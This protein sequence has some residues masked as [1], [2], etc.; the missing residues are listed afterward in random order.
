MS[1]N[2][3][4]FGHR[5]TRQ[6]RQLLP[7]QFTA[8]LSEVLNQPYDWAQVITTNGATAVSTIAVNPTNFGFNDPALIVLIEIPDGQVA[9]YE[10]N[11]PS[12]FN[13]AVNAGNSSPRISGVNIFSWDTNTTISF[14]EAASFP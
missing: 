7:S 3:R 6:I 11:V 14:V 12:R 9:R 4:V 10:F 5:G 13:G 2:I 1:F 8:N